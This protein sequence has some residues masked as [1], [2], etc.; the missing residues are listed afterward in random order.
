MT[1][2]Y[3]NTS[4]KCNEPKVQNPSS[5][6][7]HPSRLGW[8]FELTA[9][10]LDLKHES[11]TK[12]YLAGD[13]SREWLVESCVSRDRSVCQSLQDLVR[14][15]SIEHCPEGIQLTKSARIADPKIRR[16]QRVR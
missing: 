5:S 4:V 10:A 1:I 8:T 16:G 2:P 14:E 7:V 3:V 13:L 11:E 12:A 9:K 15:P 6:K